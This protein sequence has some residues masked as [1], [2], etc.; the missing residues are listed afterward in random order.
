MGA[1]F[2]LISHIKNSYI[3]ILNEISDLLYKRKCINCACQIQTGILCKTCLKT[4]QNLPSFEQGI[5]NGYKLYSAF[6]YEGVVQKLIQSLKFK[7]NKKIA[8]YLAQYLYEYLEKIKTGK[9]NCLNLKNAVIV[10]VLTHKKNYNK[11]GYDNVLLIA[12]ELS[13]LTGFEVKKA[14][15]KVKY[16]TPMYN[17]TRKERLNHI[18]NS[19]I[20]DINFDI[21]SPVILLDDIMTTGSTLQFLTGLFKEKGVKNLICLTVAKTKYNNSKHKK[22]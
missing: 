16:T 10:P 14:V 5:I 18:K 19:F 12:L 3:F 15:K 2:N 22:F 17:L 8:S 4:V 13:K 20:L 9:N 11:R 6:Y 21:K 1:K 7:H